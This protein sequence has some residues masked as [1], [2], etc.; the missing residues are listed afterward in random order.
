MKPVNYSI[1]VI[2][3]LMVAVFLQ[4]IPATGGWL[5]WKPNFLLLMVIAWV[6]YIPNQYGIRFASLVGL[7]ADALFRTPLGHYVLVF[8][9]C[10]GVAYLL[11]RWLTYF[12]MFHRAFL[13]FMLVIFGELVG[14][15][16]FSIWDIPKN[17]SQLHILGFTSAIVWVL[18]DRFVARIQLHHR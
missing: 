6:L 14:A 11:S 12:S 10:G 3:S 9:I 4:L 13:V 2:F 16:L 1:P 15:A 8:A 17:L 5:L 18:A 7:F